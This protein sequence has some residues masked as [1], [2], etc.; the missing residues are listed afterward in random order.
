MAVELVRTRGE[1]G[2]LRA[3]VVTILRQMVIEVALLSDESPAEVLDQVK[4]SLPKGAGR[5]LQ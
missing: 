5:M 1:L 2:A 3:A 4:A